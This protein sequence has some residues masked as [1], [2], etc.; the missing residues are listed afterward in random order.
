MRNA[1][2]QTGPH[3]MVVEDSR[4]YTACYRTALDSSA[5][6]Y[7]II[8]DGAAAWSLL[9]E[10][11]PRVLL[12][13]WNL[14]GMDGPTICRN[15]RQRQGGHY[16]YVIMV[17]S[18]SKLED[19]M[20]GFDAGADDYMTKPFEAAVLLAKIKVGMRISDLEQ[21]IELKVRLLADSNARQSTLI[22]TLQER[23]Q[24][25]VQRTEELNAAHR[26]LLDTARRAGM[27]EVATSV[28]HNVGNLLNTAVTSSTV[29]REVVENS[30]LSTLSRIVDLLQSHAGDLP[31]FIQKDPRGQRVVEFLGQVES[32]LTREQGMIKDKMKSLN[33]SQD[34]IRQ[35]I[36]LQQ[37]LVGLAGVRETVS[38]PDLIEDATKLFVDSFKRHEIDLTPEYPPNL[39]EITIEKAKVLQILLNLLRNARDATTTVDRAKRCVRF[40]VAMPTP[41]TVTFAVTDNGMGIKPENMSRMFNFGFTTK[42]DGHGFG[43]HG[44]VN[45]AREMG[46]NLV[47]E[48]GGEG[49]GATFTLTLPRS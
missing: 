18:N 44:C 21:S 16:V 46:G 20:T 8:A 10:K 3:I 27:A 1:K 31:E 35:I 15:L 34:Q 37:S 4:V 29:I 33:E 22:K 36:A 28:L 48:S 5:W 43:L 38:I 2:P 17:T 7:E 47:V 26:Q 25:I 45:L 39:P 14:P 41:E 30:R 32:V 13:D 49:L 40:Q 6:G 42:K 23:N 24:T 11:R 19:V 12:L 9:Q